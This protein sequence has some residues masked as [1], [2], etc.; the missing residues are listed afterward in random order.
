[1][2]ASWSW[3]SYLSYPHTR[4]HF[5]SKPIFSSFPHRHYEQLPLWHNSLPKTTRSTV[6]TLSPCCFHLAET[7]HLLHPRTS[8]PPF[9]LGIH[10]YNLWTW[11]QELSN[12]SMNQVTTLQALT[13]QTLPANT[14]HEKLQKC[15]DSD[16]WRAT[17][18]LKK[19][20]HKKS[21]IP[22]TI[23]NSN[24][25]IC[26]RSQLRLNTSSFHTPPNPTLN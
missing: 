13:Q 22:P 8:S 19:Y 10:Q 15:Q 2:G 14:H 6:P 17:N 9:F 1:M 18:Q 21:L 20:S 3:S 12:G 5:T 24:W 16:A 11:I 23:T 26:L 7:L 25:S 4:L